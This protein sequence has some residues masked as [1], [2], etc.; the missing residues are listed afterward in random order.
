M[1]V[2]GGAGRPRVGAHG[3]PRQAGQGRHGAPERHHPPEGQLGRE[4]RVALPRG[5]HRLGGEAGSRNRQRSIHPR[6]RGDAQAAHRRGE[7][8]PQGDRHG[9]GCGQVGS[10]RG[11]EAARS[12][13]G[14]Q[15]FPAARVRRLTHDKTLPDV[16][17]QIRLPR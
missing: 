12:S 13:G 2:R 6:H 14:A 17:W 1:G 4:G 3:V 11:Q 8:S 9:Q 7:A 16:L 5:V 15:H 10:A